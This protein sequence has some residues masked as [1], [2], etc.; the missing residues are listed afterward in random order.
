MGEGDRDG[1]RL[2]VGVLCVKHL[3]GGSLC[4]LLLA[5]SLVLVSFLSPSCIEHVKTNLK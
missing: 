4:F 5:G 1:R 3:G 2:G